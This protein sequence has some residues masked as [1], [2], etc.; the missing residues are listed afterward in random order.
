MSSSVSGQGVSTTRMRQDGT[1]LSGTEG[2][3]IDAA[4]PP[5]DG[6]QLAEAAR[7]LGCSIGTVRAHVAAG[8]LPSAGRYLHKALARADVEELACEVYRWRKHLAD[9]EAYWITSQRVADLLGVSRSRVSALSTRGLLPY[10]KHRDGV[11]LYRREQLKVMARARTLS[12][13]NFRTARSG[14][15]LAGGPRKA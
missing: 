13:D 1:Q 2:G 7:I 8:R 4:K 6:L 15:A 10:V 11:R 14:S 12:S 5:T 3:A 9:D